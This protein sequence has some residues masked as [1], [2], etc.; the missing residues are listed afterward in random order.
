M[1]TT[2]VSL[3]VGFLTCPVRTNLTFEGWGKA[4]L[5]VFKGKVPHKTELVFEC[6]RGR[7]LY[8]D[9]FQCLVLTSEV[10]D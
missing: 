10:F 6:R 5:V 2:N 7:T 9:K 4:R 1:N 3:N 8:T